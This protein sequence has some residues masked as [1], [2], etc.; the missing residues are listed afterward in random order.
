MSSDMASDSMLQ[1]IYNNVILVKFWC[2]NIKKKIYRYLK[3]LLIYFSVS[4]QSLCEAEF[5]SY[6]SIERLYCHRLNIET[7]RRI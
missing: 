5:S 1:L 3:M 6:I 7:D 2:G 4:S